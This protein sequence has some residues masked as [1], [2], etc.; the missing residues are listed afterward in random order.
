[1]KGVIF[2]IFFKKLREKHSPDFFRFIS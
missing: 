1:M 2:E